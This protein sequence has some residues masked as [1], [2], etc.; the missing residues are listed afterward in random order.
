MK[1][2]L[3]LY[4][5]LGF[6]SRFNYFGFCFGFTCS[7]HNRPSVKWAEF[8]FNGTQINRLRY[9]R[10]FASYVILNENLTCL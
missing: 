8:A 5:L 10:L 2:K 3:R 4:L 7:W 6:T 1:L 9:H